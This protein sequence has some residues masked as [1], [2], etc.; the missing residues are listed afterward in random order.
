MALAPFNDVENPRLC[1]VQTIKRALRTPL[2][3]FREGL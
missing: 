3:S 2:K 1:A